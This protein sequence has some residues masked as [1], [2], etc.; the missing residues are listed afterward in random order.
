MKLGIIQTRGL[1]DIVIAAPIAMYYIDRGCDVYWPIDSTFIASFSDAFPN[2]NFIPVDKEVTGSATAEYFYY[3]PLSELKKVNCE[4]IICLYSHLTG[5]DLG[6]PRLKES[7]PFDAYKYAI[8]KVPFKEKWNFHP[9]RNVV[10]EGLLFQKL[11]LE[12]DSL[13]NLI[14]EEGSNFSASLDQYI[15]NKS[16]RNIRISPI[17]DNIFDW[18]G[19]IERCQAAYLID[20]VYSNLTEQMNIKINK[21]F[22]LRS[23]ANLTPTL[24]NQWDLI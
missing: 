10:R 20:S 11:E 18:I 21:K 22:I 23:P 9:K 24:T 3:F 7:L 12:P 17:T 8:A 6:H 16:F 4:N 13:Y 15:D 1:G 19:V 14:H 2:I 5:F